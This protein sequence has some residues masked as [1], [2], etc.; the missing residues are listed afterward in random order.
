MCFS[1][2]VDLAAGLLIGAVGLDALRHVRDSVERPLAVLP[3][4][5]AAHQLVETVVWWGLQGKVPSR[6]GDAAAWLYLLIAFGVLPVLVPLTV[7]AL[8]PV[9]HRLRTGL[10]LGVGATVSVVLMSA[11][12]R[13]PVVTT[14]RGHY[15]SYDVGLWHGGALV[16]LYVLATCGSL[17]VSSHRH[18]RAWGLVNLVAV[19]VLAWVNSAGLISLWCVW[20][21]I[22]SIAIALHLRHAPHRPEARSLTRAASG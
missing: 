10:F 11:V 13:G 3:L 6:L 5:F 4:V 21:A 16:V 17:L 15:I 20:A 2:E 12:V 18:V 14:I 22:T 19:A 7:A 8:E 9:R 1:P